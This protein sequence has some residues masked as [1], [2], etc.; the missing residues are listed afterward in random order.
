[1]YIIT[2]I[3]TQGQITMGRHVRKAE[4]KKEELGCKNAA[5]RSR[6]F[7]YTQALRGF[8]GVGMNNTL[9]E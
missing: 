3:Y 4:R 5:F 2:T 6:K 8:V 7:F 9:K 1:M